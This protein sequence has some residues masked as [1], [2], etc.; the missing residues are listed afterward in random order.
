MRR[1]VRGHYDPIV[2]AP[3]SAR[4]SDAEARRVA[5]KIRPQFAEFVKRFDDRKYP[6]EVYRRICR[7]FRRPERL[8][9]DTL[10]EAL[11]WKW[12]HQGKQAI[13]TAHES[14]IGEL[15]QSWA[16]AVAGLPQAPEDAFV[17]LARHLQGKTKRFITVAFLLHLLH[18]DK[19]PIIDQHNFR[20]VNAL[21]AA[22]RPAWIIKRRPSRYED[23]KL[24]AAFMDAVLSAWRA[25]ESAP[26]ARELDKFLMMYGKHLKG[27][28][29]QRLPRTAARAMAASEHS[30]RGR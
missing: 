9:C 30:N 24:V 5:K 17:A 19:V 26:T 25:C 18:P 8:P 13:P 4:L 6:S 23:I 12:G 7:E 20:A 21:W 16:A 29:N 27:H 10:R 3:I 15:Q 28:A 1:I 11:R 22:V 14:L 2:S